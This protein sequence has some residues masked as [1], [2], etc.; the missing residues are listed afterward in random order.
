M[1]LYVVK[2]LIAMLLTLLGITM[3]TFLI[4]Q[5][6][7]GDP[8][9]A[10]MGSDKGAGEV[11]GDASARDRRED[12]IKTKKK[13]LGMLVEDHSVGSWKVE[14]S[15]FDRAERGPANK[16]LPT[17]QRAASLGEFSQW[18]KSLAASPR[19]DLV[20]AGGADK[21]IHVVETKEGTE[22]RT[23]SG[24]TGEIR[25]LA[26]SP[27][28]ATLASVDTEGGLV[29]HAVADGRELGA[30][31]P[32]TKFMRSVVFVDDARVA[33]ACDDGLVR[34]HSAPDGKVLL[35]L[36]D[37]TSFV[38]AV[39]ASKDGAKLWSAGADRKVREWDAKS[40]KLL[41]V[42][43]SAGS[44]VRDLALSP[45]GSLL[46]AA[47]DD[48]NVHVFPTGESGKTVVLP[49]HW[50]AV[51]AVAWAKD[52]RT[53]FSGGADETIRS[54]DVVEARGVTQ[55]VDKSGAVAALL[56]SPDGATLWSAA[57]SWRK[58]PA[59][60]QYG[61]WLSRVA[62]FDFDRSFRDDERVIDKIKESLPVTLGLNAIA[63]LLIYFI[64]I[65]VGVQAAVKRGSFFDVAS[66]FVLFLLY[67]APN[68]WVATL[69][70]MTL[71]SERNFN[72]FDCVGMHSAN[73]SE[74]AYLP[75]LKD[76]GAH[77]VLPI[78]ALVYAGFASLS[79]YARTTMLETIA[80]DY[81]RTARAKGLSERVVI[82]K[83]AL[84][85]SMIT[86]VTLVASLLPA[87]IGGSII[88]EQIFSIQG[89][90]QLSFQAILDR[91][92]PVIMA[93]T[94]FSAFLTLLGVLVSDVLYVVVDPRISHE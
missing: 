23:L 19:G 37:H 50:K 27:D 67:S 62:R 56:V 59:W 69:L 45:D 30:P 22:V 93:T 13:L 83:H 71:S 68:F 57:D 82:Y 88:V 17:V 92:Y 52:G 65:P 90:G 60:R 75:W 33:T 89:M 63:I 46:A 66:S 77:L 76:W 54:W 35:T 2:R 26:V 58:V 28:G 85:N 78:V 8:V 21:L 48:K 51:N 61:T 87:M 20:F 29:F 39:E 70:I 16:A 44:P 18:A 53:L 43:G 7:P 41:R 10:S 64:S 36:K 15:L 34:I 74:L 42:L 79:R 25:A 9:A 4:M 1:L 11:S 38:G 91:D 47:S 14:P 24:H 86:I 55:T 81:V 80:Q 5:A 72:W 49:G 31:P 94:T 73:A 84:R 3:V 12:A 6:A 40:G 32:L